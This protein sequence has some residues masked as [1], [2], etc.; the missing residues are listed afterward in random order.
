M[1][2]VGHGQQGYFSFIQQYLQRNDFLSDL[3]LIVGL[4]LMIP[5]AQVPSGYSALPIDA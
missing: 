5:S 1:I 3:V 2:T 4:S